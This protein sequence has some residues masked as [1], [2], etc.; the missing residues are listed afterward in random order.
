MDPNSRPGSALLLRKYAVDSEGII[1]FIE[2]FLEP[3]RFLAQRLNFKGAPLDSKVLT[4]KEISVMRLFTNLREA[5]AVSG[6]TSTRNKAMKAK[7]GDLF[8]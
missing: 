8:R 5:R 7:L 6:L 3:G 4:V 1:N 2:S